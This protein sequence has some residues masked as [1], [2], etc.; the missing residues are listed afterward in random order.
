MMRAECFLLMIRS[1]KRVS[2]VLSKPVEGAVHGVI[3]L[4]S[5]RTNGILSIQNTHEA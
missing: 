5:G 4:L 3:P 1:E 2:A